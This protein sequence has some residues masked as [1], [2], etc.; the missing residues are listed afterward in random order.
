[1][2]GNLPPAPREAPGPDPFSS[3]RWAPPTP[4]QPRSRLWLAVAVVVAVALSA[5]ALL[6]AFTRDG[7]RDG[8]MKS[9]NQT[10]PARPPNYTNE[11][12]TAAHKQLCDTYK[13]AAHAVQVDT[14]GDNPAFA[15]IATVNAAVMLMQ[16]ANDAPALA[17]NDRTAALQ[18]VVAYTNAQATASL[19]TREDPGWKVA[20]DNVNAKDSVMRSICT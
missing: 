13:L 18:L 2:S 17:S 20:V 4:V 11:Q 15:G 9:V 6:V 16:A 8:E 19:V 10:T 12:T 3:M 5:A 1:M 14:N 7:T